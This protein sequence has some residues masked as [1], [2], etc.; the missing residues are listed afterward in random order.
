[1]AT[2]AKRKLTDRFVH[3]VKPPIEGRDSYPDTEVPHFMLRVT[4]SGTKSYALNLRWPGTGEA[5]KRTVA[6]ATKVS[7]ADARKMARD[8]LSLVEQGIDPRE[9]ERRQAEAEARQRGVLFEAVVDDYCAEH[10][11]RLR[12]GE[13]DG[14]DIRRELV[15]RWRGRPITEITRDDVLAVVEE[16]KAKGKFAMAHLTLNHAKRLWRWAIHQPSWRY[17]ITTNPTREVSPAIA[18]GKK[19]QRDRVL[20]DA[21]L[22]A[23][24]HALAKMQDPAARCLQLIMLTGMRREEAA[25]L[26]WKEVDLDGERMITLPAARFKSGVKFAIP[27]SDDAM[28]LLRG[29]KRGKAAHFVFSNDEGETAVNGWSQFM[30]KLRSSV[31]ENLGDEPEQSWSPHDL[32]RTVR[33]SLSRLRVSQEIAE[34]AIGHVRVGLVGRYNLWEAMDERREAFVAWADFL[35]KIVTP[36]P[37]GKVLTMKPARRRARA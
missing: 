25:Q 4:A 10:L 32:R 29:I 24:W 15:S 26:S 33:T 12:R 3:A 5:A 37:A 30:K 17:G 22:A 28:A 13:K 7:L 14:Q 2:H 35:R 9:Q 16:I 21:E 1:M 19:A 31:A 8:Q 11:A 23:T 27:L 20:T 6:D 34:L 18:I 36:A